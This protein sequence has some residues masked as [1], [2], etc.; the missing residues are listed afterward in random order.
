[1]QPP[2]ARGQPIPV[3]RPHPPAVARQHAEESEVAPPGPQTDSP[4]PSSVPL[5]QHRRQSRGS[6][7]PPGSPE[8]RPSSSHL[9]CRVAIHDGQ[10]SGGERRTVG[11][12]SREMAW[13][14]RYPA[15]HS[16]ALARRLLGSAR[17][18]RRPP[19]RHRHAHMRPVP[20]VD[21]ITHRQGASGRDPSHSVGRLR[22]AQSRPP[23]PVS[24]PHLRRPG[25]P[26]PRNF[27]F[28]SIGGN[29]SNT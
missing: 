10:R 6:V 7:T 16:G 11:L 23:R 3:T 24:K 21:A 17:T 13:A 19:C 5:R 15:G 27:H 25:F 14:Q 12:A 29:N 2:R 8:P 22:G 18:G 4:T 1:M 9:T 28:G 26:L 20:L